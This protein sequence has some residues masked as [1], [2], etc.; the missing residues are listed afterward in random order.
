[1]SQ[2]FQP[3]GPQALQFEKSWS[4]ALCEPKPLATALGHSSEMAIQP[5]YLPIRP[6]IHPSICLSM[7]L[8][9]YL[10]PS[11]YIGAQTF[12]NI[13]RL[14]VSSC[15]LQLYTNHVAQPKQR[16]RAASLRSPTQTTAFATRRAA[17]TALAGALGLRSSLGFNTLT[18]TPEGTQDGW[19]VPMY[20]YV[21]DTCYVKMHI[22]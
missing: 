21:R 6:S 13:S 18:H 8:P 3:T 1:M 4:P 20:A 7:N 15:E 19:K 10:Y 16:C 5:I 12:T 22:P 11:I 9:I 17:G 14:C 2:C